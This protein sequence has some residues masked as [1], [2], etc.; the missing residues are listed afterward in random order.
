MSNAMYQEHILDHYENPHHQGTLAHPALE[1][2]DLNPLCGDEIRIQ[3]C[4][5]DWGQ[6]AQVCFDG[7]GCIISLA[8]ASM[9]MEAIA[10][11]MLEEV[12]KL[13]R[14]DMLEL[15]GVSLTT[16]RVKC[17]MLPWRTLVKAILL[18]EGKRGEASTTD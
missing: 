18:Y 6:L 17:A 1:F 13:D 12:K 15:L 9:L 4:L 10:G 7:K 14:Q 5:D 8:A 11:K 16:M 2:R 3:A